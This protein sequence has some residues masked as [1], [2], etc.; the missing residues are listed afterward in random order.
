MSLLYKFIC[1]EELQNV[2]YNELLT[3]RPSCT[4]TILSCPRSI[5]TRTKL[6][7]FVF[8]ACLDNRLV[9]HLTTVE[10]DFILDYRIATD[11]RVLQRATANQYTN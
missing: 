2:L 7:F 11:D 9:T 4:R 5:T 10:T 6:L 3:N 8:A 1:K